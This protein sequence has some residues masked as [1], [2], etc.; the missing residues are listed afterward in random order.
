MLF[1]GGGGMFGGRR[2]EGGVLG[3]GRIKEDG[4]CV[5]VERVHQVHQLSK[6][7]TS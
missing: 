7:V 4:M 2:G 6:V 5:W 3:E 1:G